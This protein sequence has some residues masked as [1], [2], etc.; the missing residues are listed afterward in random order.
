VDIRFG[1]IANV[2]DEG[3][4]AAKVVRVAGLTVEEQRELPGRCGGRGL[5]RRCLPSSGV[6]V[7]GEGQDRENRGQNRC[8]RGTER[9]EHEVIY[10]R[11]SPYVSQP[12]PPA[13]AFRL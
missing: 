8:G 7:F 6:H 1:A 3:H 13:A 2:I 4:L 11:L 12:G 9:S 5:A 10:D